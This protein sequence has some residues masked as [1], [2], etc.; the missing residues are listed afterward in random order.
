MNSE[1]NKGL[2]FTEFD[3]MACKNTQSKR[4]QKKRVTNKKIFE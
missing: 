3:I 2:G 4:K 1:E